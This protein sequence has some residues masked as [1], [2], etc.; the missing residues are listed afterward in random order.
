MR[1]SPHSVTRPVHRPC[2]VSRRVTLRA[3]IPRTSEEFERRRR[4]WNSGATISHVFP[5]NVATLRLPIF[6]VYVMPEIDDGYPNT[7][8]ERL[9]IS[10]LYINFKYHNTVKVS[11]CANGI[12]EYNELH[13]LIIEA[14][15]LREPYMTVSMNRVEAW[16]RYWE[17]TQASAVYRYGRLD[18]KDAQEFLYTRLVANF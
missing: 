1:Q 4:A 12:A 16:V 7:L 15:K 3:Q 9:E 6:K 14:S 10:T 18:N 8:P 5:D 13:S 2:L 11:P 17:S